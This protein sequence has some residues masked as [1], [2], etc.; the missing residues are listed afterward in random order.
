MGDVIR[1]SKTGAN[2]SGQSRIQLVWWL[3][4]SGKTKRGGHQGRGE[5]SVVVGTSRRRT[6]NAR[7]GRGEWDPGDAEPARVRGR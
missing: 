3:R 2:P 6:R 1:L 5:P 7:P 4:D